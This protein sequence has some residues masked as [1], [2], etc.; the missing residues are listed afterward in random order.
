MNNCIFCKIKLSIYRE[1]NL[2]FLNSFCYSCYVKYRK[3]ISRYCFNLSE[4]W[5][6]GI[7]ISFNMYEKN[8]IE[9]VCFSVDYFP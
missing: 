1:K 2:S 4:G 5:S 8:F 9:Y 6:K 7:N 3:L